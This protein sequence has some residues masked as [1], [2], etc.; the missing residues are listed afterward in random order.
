MHFFNVPFAFCPFLF[1][2]LF[3]ISFLFHLSF[4]KHVYMFLSGLWLEQLDPVE[5]L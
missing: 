3:Q 2:I 5:H 4:Q 1:I